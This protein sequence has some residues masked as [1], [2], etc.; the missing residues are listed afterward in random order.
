MLMLGSDPEFFVSQGGRIVSALGRFDDLGSKN[1]PSP[2]PGMKDY[3]LQLDNVLIE[4]TTPP[5]P[6]WQTFA[7]RHSVMV[8][9]LKAFVKARDCELTIVASAEM[10]EDELQDPRSFV[11]G[12]DPDFDAWALQTNPRPHSEN[13][14]LRSAGGHLHIGAEL[15]RTTKI[16]LVRLLDKYLGAYSV[17]EDPDTRRRELYGRPGAMRFKPYGVEYRVLSNFWL[18]SQRLMEKVGQIATWC[19][20]HVQDGQ[21]NYSDQEAQ[22]I[23]G[24]ITNGD[25]G[26]AKKFL[27]SADLL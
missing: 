24:M 12:C 16:L 18:Q 9:N 21:G 1:H 20:G 23:I 3:G 11:F 27:Q 26:L 15:S 8:E 13:P 22:D 6:K 4:V 5:S 25:K 10:P 2:F 19:V 14:Y 17:L 7:K